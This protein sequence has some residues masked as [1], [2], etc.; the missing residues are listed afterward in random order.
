M[1]PR[2]RS[3]AGIAGANGD[4]LSILTAGS[5]LP[6]K[7]SESFS[8]TGG[9]SVELQIYQGDSRRISRNKRVHTIELE[10]QSVELKK[11]VTLSLDVSEDGTLTTV[12]EEQDYSNAN[13]TVAPRIIGRR[14]CVLNKISSACMKHHIQFHYMGHPNII[15]KQSKM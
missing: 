15:A 3:N 7:K 12:V 1:R 2:L 11:T 9:D 10:L 8:Y 13:A 5:L 4:M 14:L 6:T